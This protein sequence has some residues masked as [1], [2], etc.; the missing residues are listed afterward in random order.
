MHIMKSFKENELRG[1]YMDFST[2][3]HLTKVSVATREY[4]V[5]R[6]QHKIVTLEDIERFVIC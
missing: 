4:W 5:G 6:A 1:A 3:F 2:A